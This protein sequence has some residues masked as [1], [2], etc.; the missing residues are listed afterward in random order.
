MGGRIE[1]FGR[2]EQ[3][4]SVLLRSVSHDLRTPL[5]AIKA[6]ASELSE[7]AHDEAARD[8]LLELIAY[9]SE[10]LDRLVANL[11]SFGRIEAGSL[12]LQRQSVDVAE[13]VEFCTARLGPTMAAKGIVVK[14]E[15]SESLPS[16]HVD[17][18]LFEQVLTNLLGNAQRHSPP[19]GVVQVL[20]RS[21]GTEVTLSVIDAGPGVDP[22]EADA[23]FLPFRS[24]TVAGTSGIGL[25][26]CKAIVEAHG[27]R[28]GVGEAPGG[29]A[30]FTVAIPAG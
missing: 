29:G 1:A 18:V 4:R 26:I 10:R 16:L 7:S 25:A 28:I 13:L 22:A 11:V 2:V 17:Y 14:T 6:A 21:D 19:G 23:I 20:G 27:G 5:S 24:G 8:R 30:K 15:V 12:V 9:E 3:R